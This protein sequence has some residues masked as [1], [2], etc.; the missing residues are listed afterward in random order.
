MELESTMDY[1][2]NKLGISLENA[3]LFVVQELLQAPSVGEIT[4]KGYVEG[5]KSARAGS[6]HPEHAAYIKQSVANLSTDTSLFRKVYKY[7]FVTGREGD[8]K[9]LSLDNALVFW[10]MLFT[11]PGLE[12]KTPN[13]DWLSL[14]KEFLGEKWTRSVNKDMWNMTLEF[15]L[16]SL[17]DESLSFWNEDGAWP[18]VIDDFVAW[19]RQKGIAKAESMDV[20]QSS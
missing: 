3:E 11:A 17:S 12:W 7:T 15:A 5:W 19:C 10:G 9:S 16:K 8:Q 20:D 18:S 14:W 6:S 13:H 2:S 4:R 1:L